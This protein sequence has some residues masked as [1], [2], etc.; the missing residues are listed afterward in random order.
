MSTANQ[1]ASYSVRANLIMPRAL[2]E[3]IA[4]DARDI[5]LVGGFSEW[6]RRACDYYMTIERHEQVA[7]LD[8]QYR[9]QD[10]AAKAQKD[11]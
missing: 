7:A 9:A 4:E 10:A 11:Q 3:V 1:V 5:G 8:A 6:V 2:A